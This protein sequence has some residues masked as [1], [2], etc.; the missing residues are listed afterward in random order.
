MHVLKKALLTVAFV[1]ITA[2]LGL[3]MPL[4]ARL[5]FDA[6]QSYPAL[7][8]SELARATAGSPMAIVILSAGRRSSAYEYGD[9]FDNQTLDALSLERTRYGAFLARKTGLPILVSGGTLAPDTEPV[10]KTMAKA[11]QFD[12]GI[13]AKWIEDQSINTA[14]NA[15]LSSNI[16]RRAGIVRVM[17][18]TH[19]WHMKRAVNAFSANGLSVTPAPTAFYLPGRSS[20]WDSLTPGLGTL[21][22]SG[23]ATHEIIG[24]V[25]YK[26]RYAY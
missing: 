14:E 22:M 15:S 4:V 26:L 23:Y 12:Y 2:T 8:P 6:L 3:S 13:Q 24:A 11:L 9:E 19:A 7:A 5:M 1:L 21:R 16:L 20:V 18:V 25:W 17:L 10:A